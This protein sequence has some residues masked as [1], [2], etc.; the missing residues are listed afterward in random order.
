MRECVAGAIE[1]GVRIDVDELERR[2]LEAGLVRDLELLLR[3]AATSESTF[4]PRK[5]E[6]PFRF[7][8]EPGVRVS[9]KIDRIDG[10]PMS[11]R[12]IVVDYKSGRA[13]SASDIERDELLQIPL[14]MLVLRDQLGLEAMGGVYV[15]VGG[16]R[17]IRGMLRDGEERVP[18]FVASDYLEPAHFDEVIEEARATAVGLVERIKEGDIKHDPHGGE[19]PSWC[20]LWRMCRKARA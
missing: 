8:L 3:A 20:D 6:V 13:S 4:V 11:A 1:T 12:G 15:P 7:E 9:G 17:K 16:V 14:Y 2:E 18:G 5:L 19:C 10:D